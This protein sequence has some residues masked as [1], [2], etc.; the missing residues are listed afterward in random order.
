[1]ARYLVTGGAGYV[2]STVAT[3]L[4]EAGHDVTV[5]DDHSAGSS[6]LPTGTTFVPGRFQDVADAVLARGDFDGVLHFAAHVEHPGEHRVYNLGN[7]V[8][9]TNHQVIEAVRATTGRPVPVRVH[10][11]R[12]GDS[13]TLVAVSD[14]ARREL[15]WQPTRG[16]DSII[17]DAW[18]FHRHHRTVP[19]PA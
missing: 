19:A 4:V 7:G 1:M 14:K 17:A 8:G 10:P 2:G 15:G 9:F 16:L 6:H 18:E 12:A 11:R 3:L 5:I 13:A